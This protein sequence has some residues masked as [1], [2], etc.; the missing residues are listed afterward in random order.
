M[1]NHKQILSKLNS[2]KSLHELT[3]AIQLVAI[4]KLASLKKKELNRSLLPSKQLLSV[5]LNEP[6]NKPFIIP[7]TTDKSCCGSINN[8][9]ME[10]VKYYA[11]SAQ[12]QYSLFLIGKKGLSISKKLYNKEL[13]YNI[14]EVTKYSLS[15]ITIGLLVDK[16]NSYSKDSCFDEY[17]IIYNYF[18]NI[19]TQQLSSLRLRSKEK[20]ISHIHKYVEDNKYISNILEKKHSNFLEDL[21]DYSAFVVFSKTL[22]ENEMS[23]YGARASSMRN[24]SKN[25]EDL[26]NKLQL[27]YNKARQAHITNE[28]IEIISCV[29]SIMSS[30]SLDKYS[31]Y[32]KFVHE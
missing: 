16:L 30:D 18:K 11:Q 31:F 9:I 12:E 28:L 3:K 2:Y 32:L 8:N 4:S 5:P 14:T 10:S 29:N 6:I 1:I 23:E 7:I 26:I 19:V 22:Y 17:V 13:N 24:A 21:Y 25:A 27:Q 15:M 20:F